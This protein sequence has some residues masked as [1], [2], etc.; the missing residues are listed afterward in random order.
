MV[1]TLRLDNY[2]PTPRK[3]VLGTNSSFGTESIKIERGAGWDGFNLTAT[4]HIPGREEPLR[5]AL[6][7]GDA[8]DVPPEVTKEAKDGVLVLA[9][10][11]S[12]VQRA[13]CN[14]EYLILEQAGV[15]GGA[16]AEPTPELA[17]QV[18]EA[19]LQ[20]KADAEAAAEDAAAAKANADK[21]QQAAENAAADAAKA[22]PYAEAARAAQEAAESARDEAIAAQQA[23]EN[24]A[25][26]A[27]ASKSAADTLAAEAA[28][29][30]LA[31]ENSKTTAINAANLAG[32]NAAAAQQAAATATDAANDAGQS[33]SDAA[34]SKAAAET[35]AK[36]AKDAQTAAAA[37][38]AEAVK[39]QGAAETA[40]KSAQDAQAAAEKA[41]DEAKAAQKGAEA[42]RDAAAKSA[43]AAAKSEANAKQSADTLAESVEN[44][45]AN[46]A[47]VA[48][49][50]EKKA[51]ID[52][53][54]LGANAWSSKH[55]IDM[56]CP[57]LEESG[58]PVV[59]YPVA[60][61][62]LDV[63]AKWEPAQEGSGTPYPAGGGKNQLNPA[64]YEAA[65]KTINGITF[66]RLNTGEVV[67]SG[68][69]TG[70]AI[71]VLI[72]SFSYPIELST[73]KNWSI[74][75]ENVISAQGLVSGVTVLRPS[76]NTSLYIRVQSGTT[77][78]TTVQ[79]QI[80]KGNT[81][82]AWE[83][84]ENIRPIKGRDSVT[85]E[86]CGENLLPFRGRLED[87]YKQQIMSSDNL[88]FLSKACAGKKLTLTFSIETKNIVFE[89][90][91]E[92]EWRKRIGFE[93]H[94]TLA[95]GTEVY[96]LQC[97]L[98][99]ANDELTKNGKKTKTL[100]VTMPKLVSGNIMFY[101]QN[102][103]SGSFVAY[104]FGIYAGTIAPTTYTP[105]I[106]Q[107]NTLTLPET[108]Y[109]G[110]VDAVTGDGNENTK[111]IMLDGTTNK[112]RLSGEFWNLQ[113]KS[114]PG[115]RDGYD[116]NCSHFPPGTFGGNQNKGYLF[117]K[118]KLMEKYFQDVNA[119]NAYLAA[120]YAA[121]TPVQVCYKLA[122]PVPF[123]ATGAQLI[124]ALAG[125]NTV[126][127]DAD[128]ATV[129]GRA[130]PIKRITDLEAAVASIN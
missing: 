14:V 67:V 30:A 108:V 83:P 88:L 63:K 76:D 17:A 73:K 36:A 68:T 11:A 78:K 55:I 51:E 86:R 106:G 130:D 27:A 37:A 103:K 92:D 102:I 128:S 22:G 104:D 122:E 115:I 105:Y 64:E 69:A 100:T 40:A 80:E 98:D 39:A 90:V 75:G 6:L 127:T 85:V 126:L 60:G 28:R 59:C 32:E 109:G 21:A 99:N 79:P 123:T 72:K 47:A 87:I 53:T 20:A 46:T 43:E 58:N 66:T 9:G 101:A 110:E 42:A 18:L 96:T 2:Y 111:I 117:T 4:W 7:D 33:A 113:Q 129:T 89:D 94:G 10:L 49:L 82:T 16:D 71:Y 45:V 35:A 62:P 97:W 15:Y 120:Q 124:P 61:Y 84:Y 3:L 5:V 65:T 112:F 41:R 57:P 81:P 12:G 13:S 31:A 116:T 74:V 114:S 77:V 70:T 91:V 50:K 119:F 23:A 19:A 44:V 93:C 1:H 52:D 54:V 26:A 56:L 34:A 38:K 118:P 29:A 24:A 121:G 107:T 25:A 125:V 8:M 48:E 95:D